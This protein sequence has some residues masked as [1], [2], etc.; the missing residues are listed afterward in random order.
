MPMGAS[1]SFYRARIRRDSS[2]LGEGQ[3]PGFVARMIDHGFAFNGP[4]WDYRIRRCRAYMP[5]RWCMNRS[6]RWTT[7]G[8]GSTW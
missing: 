2:E 3:P 6:A 1:A 5:A 8:L 7:F 4:N